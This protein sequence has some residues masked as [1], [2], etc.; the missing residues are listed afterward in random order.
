MKKTIQ[1]SIFDEL[2]LSGAE[3]IH[4][5]LLVW[6]I[7]LEEQ[8]FPEKIDFL[9]RLFS[10]TDQDFANT[11]AVSEIMRIDLVI[12]SEKVWYFLEN[13]LTSSEHSDQTERYSKSIE[14]ITKGLNVTVRK[15]FLTLIGEKPKSSEWNVITYESL[16][17]CLDKVLLNPKRNENVILQEYKTTLNNLVNAYSNFISKHKEFPSV[18]TNGSKTKLAKLLEKGTFKNETERYISK[19]QLETIFQKGFLNEVMKDIPFQNIEI[20]ETNGIAYAQINIM[21]FPRYNL[22]IQLQQNSLKINL[23]SKD[24]WNSIPEDLKEE[25]KERFIHTF[26]NNM[27]YNRV[28]LGKSRA[29]IS[30]SKKLVINNE[31]IWAMSIFEIREFLKGEINLILNKVESLKRNPEWVNH[32]NA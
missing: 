18:F 7:N 19:Y 10:T 11:E 30:V 13:K 4:T 22:G 24:Y 32:L 23:M 16:L 6:L 21:E 8:V 15:Y 9:R 27:G 28:N 3:R 29:Y 14:E 20:A 12:K 31:A 2:M 17:N 5:Q 1:P 25:A 26:Q